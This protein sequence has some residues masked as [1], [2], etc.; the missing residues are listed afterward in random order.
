M[1]GSKKLTSAKAV[2]VLKGAGID[3]P[4]VLGV[5]A[6][7]GLLDAYAM[8][9]RLAGQRVRDREENGLVARWFWSDLHLE[10]LDANWSAGIFRTLTDY[11]HEYGPQPAEW[12]IVG[13]S[14][15]TDQLERLVGGDGRGLT[16][17]VVSLQG[18]MPPSATPSDLKWEEKA[19]EAA[20]VIRNKKVSRAKAFREVLNLPEGQ[21]TTGDESALRRSFDGMYDRHGMRHKI[22]SN[23]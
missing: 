5:W 21:E 10:T 7:E 6:K 11:D 3:D 18:K 2:Q 8:A 4:H 1:T 23:L 20:E 16:K 17:S 14:F 13:V 15:N 19:H 9:E 22:L 12:E